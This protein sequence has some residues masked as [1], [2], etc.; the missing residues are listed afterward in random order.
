MSKYTNITLEEMKQ[1]LPE[2][3]RWTWKIIGAEWVA[4]KRF[5][6]PRTDLVVRVYSSI[7]EVTQSSRRK[8]VDCIRVIGWRDQSDK[9]PAQALTSGKNGRVL[10]VE[11]WRIN[12]TTRVQ[13]VVRMAW[14]RKDWIPRNKQ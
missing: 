13:E 7:G 14:E 11:G 9:F 5:L 1:V 4:E 6:E 8:G 2:S 12:L 3:D 10:R